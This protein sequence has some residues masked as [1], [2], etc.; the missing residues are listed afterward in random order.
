MSRKRTCIIT[1]GGGLIGSEAVKYFS[2]K[3]DRIALID[4]NARAEFFGPEASVK[5]TIDELDKSDVVRSIWI[6]IA[7]RTEVETTFKAISE[8]AD[9]ELVIHCAAQPSHDW[10]AS[11]PYRDFEV[12]A[13]GTLNLLESCR[14][15]SPQ[16][17]F[18]FMSTNKVYGDS[19]NRGNWD[20]LETRYEPAGYKWN[21]SVE[22]DEKQPIDQSLHSLFGVSKASADLMT[23]EYG[24]YFG[25]KTG[26][27]RG[28]CLTGPAHKGAQ[29]H[30]FLSYLVKCIVHEKEYTVIG[31]KGKQVRDQ[32]HSKDVCQA[33]DLFYRN[34]K[35]GAVYNI[36][37]GRHSNCSV[38]E[39]IDIVE[40][41]T[42][43][44]A[45]VSFEDTPRRGDHQW[46]IT[47]M[48]SF[49]RDYPEFEYTY[50]LDQIIDE[51][52]QS[53]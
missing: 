36:G 3:F 20:E 28:G 48:S 45:N 49:R 26:V 43:K 31:Y 47:D 4:N 22:I 18:I 14:Q 19:P 38:L 6:D 24:R 50:T 16:A 17:I 37:G 11:N 44:K 42:G 40:R 12:N 35:P 21:W 7:N 10:A 39:A 8:V 41:K 23:Q 32:I 29:L 52:I 13:M 51:L 1:G 33:F 34:P 5:S 30:G 27:F 2:P 53:A 9:I 15:F 46:Y 25:M